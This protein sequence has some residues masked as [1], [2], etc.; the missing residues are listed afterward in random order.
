M[1]QI[2]NCYLLIGFASKGTTTEIVLL[3]TKDPFGILHKTYCG[4]CNV[5]NHKLKSLM[6][7][8]KCELCDGNLHTDCDD[9]H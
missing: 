1:L 3:A 9:F 6:C 2:F 7:K 5:A 4:Q 8:R